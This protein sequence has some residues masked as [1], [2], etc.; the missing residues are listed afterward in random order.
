MKRAAESTDESALWQRLEELEMEEELTNYEDLKQTQRISIEKTSTS[1]IPLR[2]SEEDASKDIVMNRSSLSTEEVALSSGKS[3]RSI[4]RRRPS[5]GS[6]KSVHFHND[7]KDIQ[8][9]LDSD[10]DEDPPVEDEQPEEDAFTGVI[11]ERSSETG[12]IIDPPVTSQPKRVSRFKA[13]RS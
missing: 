11:L 7:I 9:T 10:D 8:Q 1:E 5:D 4:L 6:L 13:S 12:D 3:P 2:L